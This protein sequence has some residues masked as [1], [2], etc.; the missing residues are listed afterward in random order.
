[1]EETGYLAAEGFERELE[2]ELAHVTK[3]YGRLILAP[4]APRPAAWAQNVWLA[5]RELEIGS[6]KDSVLKLRAI[7]RNWALYDFK[8]HRRAKLIQEQLPHVSA[9]PV[10][11][12]CELPKAPLGSWTLVAENRILASARCSSPFRHGEVA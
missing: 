8:L 5:P 6:I 1:M 9:K 11:F 3:R 12:P 7:Q 2:H 4:G 10:P